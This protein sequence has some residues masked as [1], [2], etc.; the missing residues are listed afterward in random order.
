MKLNVPDTVG[1]P[2]MEPVDPFIA[3]PGGNPLE[4]DQL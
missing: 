3:K 1:V 4:T 2:E